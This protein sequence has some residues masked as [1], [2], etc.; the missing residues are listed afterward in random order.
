MLIAFVVLLAFI[1]FV[2]LFM[3]QKQFGKLPSG[4]RLERIRSSPQ[5]KNGAF[6]NIHYTPQLTEGESMPGLLVKFLFSSRG[7]KKPQQVLPSIKTDLKNLPADKNILVWFGHSSY[8]MQLDGKKILVDPVMSGS[9][10]PLPGG[11]RAFKGTDIY[12]TDDIPP[13]DY[14]FITHDHWDHLD[15]KTVTALQPK[16]KAVICPLGVGEH[17]E[18]WGFDSAIIHENDWGD[19]I[20]L[21]DGFTVTLTPGRHFAGRTLKRNSSL[22]TS[23]V[24]RSPSKNIFI[25]GDS[26]YDT[27]FAEIGKKFGPFDWAILENGQYDQSWRYIHLLPEEFVIAAK[28]INAKNILPLHSSKFLL[29]NHVWNEP[30]IRLMENNKTAGLPVATPQIGEAVDLDATGQ[31]F[32]QWWQEIR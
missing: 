21:P 14:L 29:G 5:Y 4:K 22:W 31:A 9:A 18:Y 26:G 32:G 16:I 3:R 10:S 27:H 8:F 15:Y 7:K 19:V 30:L 1:F 2:W 28:E 11:T 12:T 23:Y 13:I 17:L 20:S 6:Q 24:L 25:G